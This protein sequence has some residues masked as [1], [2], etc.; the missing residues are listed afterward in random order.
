[1]IYDKIDNWKTY[2]HHPIFNEIF[3]ALKKYDE[4]TE[5]G[6]YKHDGFYFKVMEYDTKIEADIIETHKKEVDIQLLLSGSE[7]IKM[8]HLDDL[9]ISKAYDDESD[10]V[11]YSSDIDPYTELVLY[12][13]YMAVFFP[14]DPHRPQFQSKNGLEKL[15][16]IVIKVNLE[17]FQ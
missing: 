9:L 17:F 3:T 8:Y 6:V 15:K 7:L 4:N 5:N 13:K 16:K 1:M 12:P 14:S 2:F 11:F 10:C